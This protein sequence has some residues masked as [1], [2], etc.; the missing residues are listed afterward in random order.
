M[1]GTGDETVSET[2]V[3]VELSKNRLHWERGTVP[4]N[5]INIR[6]TAASCFKV[7]VHVSCIVRSEQASLKRG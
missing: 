5:H 2:D 3:I 1:L 4:P 7:E 6:E